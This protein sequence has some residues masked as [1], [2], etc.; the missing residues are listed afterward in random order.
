MSAEQNS[1]CVR[2]DMC[3]KE[4]QAHLS[5]TVILNDK[6]DKE[7][8]CWCVCSE[9]AGKFK[10]EVKDFYRDIMEGKEGDSTR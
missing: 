2:C 5:C 1:A 3:G 9:C 7:E 8:A 6:D 4:E 10:T